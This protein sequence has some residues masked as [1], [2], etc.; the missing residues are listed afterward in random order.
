M[1]QRLGVRFLPQTSPSALLPEP[2]SSGSSAAGSRLLQKRGASFREGELQVC[3]AG[4][5]AGSF[6]TIFCLLLPL[7]AALASARQPI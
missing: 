2:S 1:L 7:C 3:A 4:R 5:F 6:Q